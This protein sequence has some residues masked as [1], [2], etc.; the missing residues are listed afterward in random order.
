MT[1]FLVISCHMVFK[2]AYFVEMTKGYQPAKFNAVD[3]LGR[4]LQ[5]DNKNTIMTS[6]HMLGLKISIF[7][8]T[9]ISYQPAKL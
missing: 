3:C 1:S 9:D 7:C 4:V 5:R 8:E 2:F 6:I